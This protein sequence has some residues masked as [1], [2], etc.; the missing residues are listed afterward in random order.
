MSAI[1]KVEHAV[2]NIQHQIYSNDE[3]YDC[4]NRGG[5]PRFAIRA[6]RALNKLGI[7]N[8]MMVEFHTGNQETNT[9][10]ISNMRKLTKRDKDNLSF[11]HCWVYI[12]KLRLHFDGKRSERGDM[13]GSFGNDKA[14]GIYNES[15]MISVTR[16]GY[17]NLSYNPYLHNKNLSKI[18]YNE[19]N[20]LK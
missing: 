1:T 3:M 6:H 15:Q 2:N 16:V 11:I 13:Y 20:K 14:N 18:I 4:I 7:D 12:P 5:C 10:A 17:W 8:K 19:F 9:T